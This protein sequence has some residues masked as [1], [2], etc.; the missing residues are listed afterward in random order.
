MIVPNIQQRLWLSVRRAWRSITRAGIGA[1][2]VG[3]VFGEI[4]GPLFNGGH[5]TAFVHLVSLILGL[6]MAYGAIVTV[7]IFQAIRGIFTVVND[8]ETQVRSTVGNEFSHVV[9]SDRQA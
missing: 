1:A 9:E 6:A 4:G 2:L 7:G 8:L 5:T 3:I